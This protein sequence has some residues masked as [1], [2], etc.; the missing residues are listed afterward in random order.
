[1]NITKI[2]VEFIPT[3][4]QR[5]LTVGDYIKDHGHLR[6][7]VS[8]MND[9]RHELLVAVHE[10]IEAML[11]EHRGIKEED[12]TA[13]DIEFEKK[14]AEYNTDEP[15]DDSAAPYRKEHLFA[16]GIEKLLASELDVDW[17]KYDEEVNSL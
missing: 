5:Y 12:I 10:V 1:M 15:G 16:T 2:T 8:K 6:V 3:E 9:N 14:R 7:F 11:T 4:N 13:F 17:K